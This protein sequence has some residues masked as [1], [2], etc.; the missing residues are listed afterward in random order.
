M[1]EYDAALKLLLKGSPKLLMQELAGSPVTKWIDVELLRVE[2]K[3]RRADLFGETADGGFVHIELQTRN[4]PEMHV[5][6][7]DYCARAYRYFRR[8]PD[9]VVFY[10]GE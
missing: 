4:D 10:V 7:L 5:R 9:Q 1:Q 6:M 2:A 3:N 8:V